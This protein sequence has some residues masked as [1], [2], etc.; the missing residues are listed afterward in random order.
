MFSLDISASQLPPRAVTESPFAKTAVETQTSTLAASTDPDGGYFSLDISASLLEPRAVTESPFA[1]TPAPKPRSVETFPSPDLFASNPVSRAASNSPSSLKS[2]KATPKVAFSLASPLENDPVAETPSFLKDGSTAVTP[3]PLYFSNREKS[4]TQSPFVLKFTGPPPGA[5]Q[6]RYTFDLGAVPA[7]QIAESPFFLKDGTSREATPAA[8]V[9]N[10]TFAFSFNS[11]AA[12]PSKEG[13]ECE[14]VFDRAFH[15]A[16]QTPDDDEMVFVGRVLEHSSDEDEEALFN[17]EDRPLIIDNVP[18]ES[19]KKIDDMSPSSIIAN[20]MASILLNSDYQSCSQGFNQFGATNYASYTVKATERL[21]ELNVDN[22]KRTLS[23]RL[24][25]DVWLGEEIERSRAF[26]Q[27]C[28]A[29]YQDRNAGTP[30]KATPPTRRVKSTSKKQ[31]VTRSQTV[32]SS[33]RRLSFQRPP[34]TSTDSPAMSEFDP[35]DSINTGMAKVAHILT[36]TAAVNS[37]GT[38]LRLS[39]VANFLCQRSQNGFSQ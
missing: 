27:L 24:R 15:D 19:L 31:I 10:D 38:A 33:Q 2:P 29:K 12:P 32:L 39:N 28:Q 9:D 20:S 17:F 23:N 35:N 13:S 6:P 11:P 22:V 5:S 25:S 14:S 34:T 30:T 8:A 7:S 37:P 26:L 16:T 36:A 18:V 1:S 4:P 21:A 3:M